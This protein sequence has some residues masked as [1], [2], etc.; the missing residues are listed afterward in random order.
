MV[1]SEKISALFVILV[2]L[3]LTI[4]TSLSPSFAA[5]QPNLDRWAKVLANGKADTLMRLD[6]AK[7]LGEAK[8]PN[9]LNSLT[10]ALKD[11]NKAVRWAAAEALWNLG[12]KRAVPA[13]IAYLEKKKAYGWGQI[14]TMNAL[15]SLKDPRAV[16]PLLRMLKSENPFLRRSAALALVKIGDEK[17]IPGI[18]G[19]LKDEQGWLQRLAQ[20]LIVEL[21]GEKVPAELPR[22]YE[23]W[24]KWYQGSA[25][26]L[27]IEEVRKK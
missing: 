18:I 14:L 26:H 25:G 27:K 19:L 10:E 22:G 2:A 4:M 15:G 6:A 13:L 23:A 8:D 5:E 16:D 24:V 20:D 12:D 1:G 3:T 17:A 9:Y 7:K 21:T 11:G